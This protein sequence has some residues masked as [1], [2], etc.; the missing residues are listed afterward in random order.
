[1][2][3]YL[4]RRSDEALDAQSITAKVNRVSALSS[5]L[6]TLNRD[7]KRSFDLQTAATWAAKKE[8]D[9]ATARAE[10]ATA[11]AELK[12]EHLRGLREMMRREITEDLKQ[13]QANARLADRAFRSDSP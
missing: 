5:E 6:D 12:E 11:L 3:A 1:M 10:S 7:L 2:I 13:E 9:E 8:G 4:E